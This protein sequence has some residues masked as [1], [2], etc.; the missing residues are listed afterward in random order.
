MQMSESESHPCS[1]HASSAATLEGNLKKTERDLVSVGFLHTPNFAAFWPKPRKKKILGQCAAIMQ[2]VLHLTPPLQMS[3]S[4]PKPKKKTSR[5]RKIMG[6]CAGIM[7]TVL[8]LTP[9]PCKCQAPVQKPRN[10]KILTKTNK[11]PREIEKNQ[12]K[13]KI[14]GQYTGI[15]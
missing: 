13:T 1:I 10:R 8:H 12:K 6:Q 7:Q 5:N 14:L 3:G 4:C 15:M 9:P 11:K 2:T